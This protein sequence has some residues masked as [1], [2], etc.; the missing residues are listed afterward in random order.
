M[1]LVLTKTSCTVSEFEQHLERRLA[2]MYVMT[3]TN[4]A[5]YAKNVYR[6][7]RYL[8]QYV[9]SNLATLV[10]ASYSGLPCFVFFGLHSE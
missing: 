2:T 1:W 6:Y 9:N 10:L 4:T 5:M 3:V 7:I 8:V